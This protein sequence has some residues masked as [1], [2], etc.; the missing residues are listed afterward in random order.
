[1][2][3][4]TD[5]RPPLADPTESAGRLRLSATRLARRL[6]QEADAGLT[7]SMLSAL[8][9]IDCHG[10]LTLGALADHER[11]APP[12]ITKL[13]ARLEAEGLV[14]RSSD[15]HD[16]RVTLVAT[17]AEGAGLLAESRRRKTAWLAGRIGTLEPDQQRRL[18]DALD[19]LDALTRPTRPDGLP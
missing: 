15:P 7:P 1:M 18:A 5:V 6:R 10:P 11:V 13:V 3:V 12:S 16:G 9:V 19:V 2:P 8:A 14:V 17:S 4:E